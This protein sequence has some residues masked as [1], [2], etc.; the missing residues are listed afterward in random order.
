ME[1]KKKNN[2]M[3]DSFLCQQ[4]MKKDVWEVLISLGQ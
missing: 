1:K 4:E 2:G 3:I